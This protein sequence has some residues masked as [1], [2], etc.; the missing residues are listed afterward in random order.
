MRKI[1]LAA[2]AVL[3]SAPAF[4]QTAVTEVTQVTTYG[5]NSAYISQAARNAAG[6]SLTQ[7]TY[8]G[9]NVGAISQLSRN[10]AAVVAQGT[11]RGNNS[12]SVQQA[13]PTFWH[14]HR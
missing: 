4:A 2:A 11:Y 10:T 14:R 12:I 5:N 6:A 9:N 8:R 3:V 7:V 1:I 13:A